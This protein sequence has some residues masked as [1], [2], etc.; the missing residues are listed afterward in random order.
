MTN[1]D[2]FLDAMSVIDEDLLTAHFQRKCPTKA[3]KIRKYAMA[4]AAYVAACLVLVIILPFI[5]GKDE[6]YTPAPGDSP[7]VVESDSTTENNTIIDKAEPEPVLPMA[8]TTFNGCEFS[9]TLD[10]ASYGLQDTIHATVKLENKGDKDVGLWQ[11]YLGD[12][13][14]SVGFYENGEYRWS[15]S[16]DWDKGYPEA[17]QCG[18]IAPGESITHT[19]EFT[20]GSPHDTFNHVAREDSKWEITASVQYYEDVVEG[21]LPDYDSIQTATVTIEVP[22][23]KSEDTQISEPAPDD[24]QMSEP[25]FEPEDT[26]VTEPAPDDTQVTEPVSTNTDRGD[27]QPKPV[28][29]TT[30]KPEDDPIPPGTYSL[31]EP[32]SIVVGIADNTVTLNKGTANFARIKGFADS[33]VFDPGWNKLWYDVYVKGTQAIKNRGVYAELRYNTGTTVMVNGGE[34]LPAVQRVLIELDSDFPKVLFGDE[35][36]YSGE[37]YEYRTSDSP[38]M[39][40]AVSEIVN[41]KNPLKVSTEFD[42]CEYTLILDKTDYANY[43]SELVTTVRATVIL[44]NKGDK[45]ITLFKSEGGNLIS[46]MGFYV[47]GAEK[48]EYSSY[49]GMGHTTALQYETFEPGEILVFADRFIPSGSPK[50]AKWEITASMNYFTELIDLGLGFGYDSSK[51][52][53]KSLTIEV[54]HQ[55]PE[56]E[57]VAYPDP[58]ISAETATTVTKTLFGCEYTVTIDKAKY[59]HG[60]TVNAVV[61]LANKGK[62]IIYLTG[63]HMYHALDFVSFRVDGIGTIVTGGPGRVTVPVK[64]GETLSYTVKYDTS[65]AKLTGEWSIKSE[66]EYTVYGKEYNESIEIEVSHDK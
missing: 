47:N 51:L 52:H 40:K 53:S 19:V 7:I 18:Q 4:A 33:M 36:Y 20:P 25:E 39:V 58:Y 17:I 37:I 10:K 56:G 5:I 38:D 43:D 48:R 9:I 26:Q 42:G 49:W 41:G 21:E 35:P 32:D 65:E 14:D 8:V 61:T 63:K 34:E 55:L 16:S 60:D 12:F 54:P 3:Q 57:Y 31:P 2:K 66:I 44:E 1:R 11:G 50:D 6:I 28:P 45:T 29:E 22:H 64:P 23:G 59:E 30:P 46:D 13:L 24:T 62:A 27:P 15:Y